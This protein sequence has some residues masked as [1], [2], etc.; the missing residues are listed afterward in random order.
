M[1][2]IFVY[3]TRLPHGVPEM[4]VPCADG[5]TI[6][7]SDQL[8]PERQRDKYAHAMHHIL[9]GDHDACGDV[10]QIESEAHAFT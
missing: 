9:N 2:D 8:T 7:I 6:Y 3:F 10:Q 4:V 1:V 5:Y